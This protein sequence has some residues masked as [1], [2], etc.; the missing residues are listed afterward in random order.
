MSS[1]ETKSL[2]SG[3]SDRTSKED[4][5]K[6]A[7]VKMVMGVFILYLVTFLMTLPANI[8]DYIINEW[9]QFIVKKEYFINAT[10][11]RVSCK[12][13]NYSTEFNAN[14]TIVQQESAKWLM[15][16]S[17]ANYIPGFFTSLVLTPMTD[18]YGRRFL[19]ILTLF[20]IFV[21]NAFVCAIIYTNQ[22]FGYMVAA[23][24]FEGLTGSSFSFYSVCFSYIADYVT[25]KSKRMMCFVIME[26]LTMAS[27]M[28]S[29]L[30]AAV[31]I[32]NFGF[33]VAALSCTTCILSSLV[34]AILF[35][36]ESLK[37]EDRIRPV[38]IIESL[39]RPLLFYT[40]KVFKGKRLLYILFLMAF[41]LAELIGLHRPSLETL[42]LLGMPFCFSPTWIG[43]FSFAR[44]FSETIIGLG[45][46]KFL[47][48]YMTNEAIAILST[49]SNI[50]SYI[51][52]ALARSELMLFMGKL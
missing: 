4:Q 41:G 25:D 46:V 37:S 32:N 29:G 51:V 39:F 27:I 7:F 22:Q 49:V 18:T 36:P 20:G 42:Y 43:Y 17:I 14:L 15:L 31:L 44:H 3:T 8:L 19:L 30:I 26:F 6:N 10:I 35:L 16:S 9:T 47:Q 28:V 1:E 45:S 13:T 5:N 2:L 12:T 52:E 50:L 40:S 21:K 34:T 33:S 38:S 23:F 11:S 24:A 48:A